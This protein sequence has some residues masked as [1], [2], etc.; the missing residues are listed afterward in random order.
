[1]LK[2]GLF[3]IVDLRLTCSVKLHAAKATKFVGSASRLDGLPNGKISLERDGTRFSDVA[4]HVNDLGSHSTAFG[5]PNDLDRGIR[6]NFS[7][8]IGVLYGCRQCL[9]TESGSSHDSDERQVHSAALGNRIHCVDLTFFIPGYTH[10]CNLN[11]RAGLDL[12]KRGAY[13]G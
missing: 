7:R 12:R 6:V 2:F 8:F 10:D 13:E 9:G 11:G 1:M 4:T 3:N 5:C